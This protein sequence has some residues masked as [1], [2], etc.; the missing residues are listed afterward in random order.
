MTSYLSIRTDMINAADRWVD[1]QAVAAQGII[2]SRH[3]A[4]LD[5]FIAKIAE[6]V[7]KAH[8]HAPRE[9]PFLGGA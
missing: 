8:S 6:Q 5:A 2:T 3:P 7:K 9:R 4:D 1:H